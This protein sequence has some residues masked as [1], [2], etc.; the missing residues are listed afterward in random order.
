MNVVRIC[1]ELLHTLAVWLTD[2]RCQHY[3]ISSCNLFDQ[4]TNSHYSKV[5]ATRLMSVNKQ[6]LCEWCVE[7]YIYKC[8]ELS[9]S[10]AS[11]WLQ[12]YL[13]RTAHDNGGSHRIV[14]LQNAVSAIVKFRLDT[15]PILTVVRL[16]RLQ[17]SLMSLWSRVSVTLQS[18]LYCI[19]LLRKTD[20]TLHAYFT[21]AIF[22]HVAYR[23]T[24]GS[25]TDEMLDVLATTCLQSNDT[26]RCLN[27]R[28]SSELS[29]SQAVM[30]MKVVANNSR[31]TVQLIEIE[32]SK[33]Y[34]HR[35]LRCKDS[36]SNSI[37]CL[38]NVYLALLYYTTGQYQTAI[39]HC[40]LVTR[41]QDHCQCSSHV[42]QGELLPANN[43]QIVNILG[44]AV[45][46][47]YIRA[48]ALN[49]EQ[50]RPH[51]SVFTTELFAYYLLVKF[52]S[53]T[54]CRQLSPTS[55]ADE[56]QRYRNCLCNSPDVFVTDVMAFNFASHT[57]F[58]SNNRRL[59]ADRVET[60]SLIVCELDTSKLVELLQQSAVE[61][62]TSC[63]ELQ[64][65]D[66]D[67]LGMLFVLHDF[68]AFY[69]YRCGQYQQCLQLSMYSAHTMIVDIDHTVMWSIFFFP[70]FIQLLDD[71]IA[72]LIGLVTLVLRPHEKDFPFVAIYWPCLSLYLMAQCQIKLRHP[73]TSLITTL[74]YVRIA[75]GK[76]SKDTEAIYTY[77][78]VVL[79]FVEQKILKCL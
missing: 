63:P 58:L 45:F 23:T 44:L 57:K 69:A 70:E 55:L 37:Y 28:H 50:E 66:L 18:C 26:R 65:P 79:K 15:S 16:V 75:R 52:L 17:C 35:A 54:E 49:E 61:H 13:S 10:S 38:A 36:D 43:D 20:Q 7:V 51:A 42:V 27:A 47:Q 19:S 30:L 33:A 60:K 40:A 5:T 74:E 6:L 41:L 31:S 11:S 4:F 32:L 77:S 1:V 29:L 9:L 62:L 14:C 73:V 56:I 22:L 12:Q 48:A 53:V 59:M 72:S 2:A 3:F 39:D 24:Q 34:L 68:K 78:S 76:I 8:S 71:D 67:S 46:Y 25:L 21:A 64:S